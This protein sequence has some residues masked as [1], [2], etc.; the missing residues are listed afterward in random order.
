MCPGGEEG[1]ETNYDKVK[2]WAQLHE[3]RVQSGGWYWAE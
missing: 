3:L 1:T 2:K